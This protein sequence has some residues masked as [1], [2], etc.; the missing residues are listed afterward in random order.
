MK[1]I[2]V[3]TMKGGNISEDIHYLITESNDI[4]VGDTILCFPGN[5]GVCVREVK[6]CQLNTT[7]A[8]LDIVKLTKNSS[9]YSTASHVGIIHDSGKRIME[10][11]LEE[12]K[13]WYSS[14]NERLRTLA[15]KVFDKGELKPDINYIRN[16]T[17]TRNCTVSVPILR[18][19]KCEAIADL[20]VIARHFNGTWKKNKD[21]R[22]YYIILTVGGM[23][24]VSETNLCRAGVTYF[25]NE[26]DAREALDMLGDKVKHLF[27]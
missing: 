13:E 1:R 2:G 14:G 12:A 6:D 23:P 9:R 21:N 7:D 18:V 10:V 8:T 24:S 19:S 17:N 20:E 15:L 5:E 27:D 4:K 22:G 26:K 11:S 16:C 3:S 25:K